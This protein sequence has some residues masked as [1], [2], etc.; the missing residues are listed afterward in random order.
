MYTPVMLSIYHY[1]SFSPQN[2]YIGYF[3]SKAISVLH[4][5]TVQSEKN[6]AGLFI[7]YWKPNNV[8]AVL[9]K[10][11]RKCFIKINSQRAGKS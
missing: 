1:S 3:H 11:T 5:K 9:Y 4:P 2:V 10:R 8:V 6:N 7:E